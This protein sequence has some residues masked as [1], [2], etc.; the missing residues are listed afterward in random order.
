MNDYSMEELM[1]ILSERVKKYT[2]ND[3]TSVTYVI[4]RQLMN[5]ILYCMNE[6]TTNVG[7]TNEDLTNKES[8]KKESDQV[9]V[10]D[11]KINAVDA[12]RNGLLNKK[13]KITRSKR[14]FLEINKTFNAYHNLCY[15]ET[16]IKGMPAF[17]AKYDV[18]FDA[19]NHILSLDYPLIC[20]I[21]DLIG[22]DIIY[23]YL[24][25]IQLEQ[26]F[27]SKFPAE[28]I[29][30]VLLGFHE[31]YS[32]YIFN[33]CKV[34][35]RNVLGCI[36]LNKPIN[37]LLMEDSDLDQL[38]NISTHKSQEELAIFLASVLEELINDKF[39]GNK[40][41]LNYLKYDMKEFAFEYKY[42]SESES[43]DKLFS[44]TV[45]E[46]LKAEVWFEEGITMED[47]K[48]RKLIDEMK[49]CRFLSDKLI[50]LEKEVKG[51]TDLKEI[52]KECFYKGEF[53]EVFKLLSEQ[54]RKVLRDEIDAKVSTDEDLYEW[55]KVL[56]E[57]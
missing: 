29:E 37:D 46:A 13:K 33:V 31:E 16:V 35:L 45:I 11:E 6:D 52:L 50:M 38:L 9:R 51:L 40:E 30:K 23:E 7:S 19:G 42:Y 15:Y 28:W 43:L 57:L 41:L 47:D 4:A 20:E 1:P 26:L 22:I 10:V 21:Q 39:E 32:D 55:E 8:K 27:L 14:L 49:E 54:E 44:K 36:I 48:L 2:S 24:R 17:F 53:T 56:W 25:R 12:F 34:V 3:S 5:S 18:E